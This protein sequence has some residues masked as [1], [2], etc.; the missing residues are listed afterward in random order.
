MNKVGVAIV[1]LWCVGGLFELVGAESKPNINKLRAMYS[2]KDS[3]KW[4]KAHIDERI[5]RE[6][7]KDLGLPN[8]T[9]KS[10]EAKIRAHIELRA[11]PLT[12]PYPQS[13][14]FSEEK[15]ALGERL[16]NDPRLSKSE[17]IACASC[18]DRY[19]AFGDGKPLSHGHN[20]Q[21]GRRNAPNIMMSAFST[22]NFWDGRAKDLES[23]SLFP[24]ADPK[25]MASTADKA[26]KKLNGIKEY[27]DEFKK[28][29]GTRKITKELMAKAIATYER[30]LMPTQTRFDLFLNGESHR[31]TD[32]EV[33]GLHI[34]RT[35]AQ[36]L[37]CHNGVALTD[38]KYYNLGLHNYGR[39]GEDLGRFEVTKDPLDMGKFKT[40]TLRRVA[41]SGPYF[42]N[43]SFRFMRMVLMHYNMGFFG[44][45][46]TPEQK[47]DPL[48]PKTDPLIR[49][50]GLNLEEFEALEAFMNVL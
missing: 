46:P 34:Y 1:F 6:I 15:R 7:A 39:E 4:E 27:K 12:P 17:Q 47:N 42:H 49:P 30:S 23:Q 3:S 21:V 5:L 43:G 33:L 48:F 45:N 32:K 31:L 24:I 14:P 2:N 36:C 50:L 11:L 10:N 38:N 29:F 19:L 37:N 25:E 40:P 35:K 16:F 28:A 18:H 20:R 26:A 44:G 41:L 22:E 13:N 9:D 8:H